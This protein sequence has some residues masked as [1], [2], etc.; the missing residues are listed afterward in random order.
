MVFCR[1][2]FPFFSSTLPRRCYVY[3]NSKQLCRRVAS[4]SISSAKLTIEKKTDKKDWEN[5]PKKENLQFGHT[6]SD[7]MLM[8]DWNQQDGWSDPRIIPHQDLRIS[9]AATSLHYGE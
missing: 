9:P 3:Y 1:Q 4:R 2:T 5:R 7:H 6:F 8:I